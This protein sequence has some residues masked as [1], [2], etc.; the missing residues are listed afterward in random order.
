ML[1]TISLPQLKGT[2]RQTQAGTGFWQKIPVLMPILLL[3]LGLAFFRI[4]Q[5]SFWGDEIA[6]I[7]GAYGDSL[8]AA[9]LWSSGHGPLYFILL[10][11]WMQL[12]QTEF[13]VRSLSA[14][15]AAAAVCLT[16]A[17]GSRLVDRR[18]AAIAATLFAASP[19]VIWY[20]QETRYI[21]LAIVTVLFSMYSFHRALSTNAFKFWLLY[22]CA[23]AMALFAFVPNAFVIMGQGIYVVSLRQR[24]LILRWIGYL[25]AVMLIFGTWLAV[26]YGG[27]TVANITGSAA[28][29]NQVPVASLATG[30]PREL[31]VAVVPYTLFAFTS[32]FSMGP[33][34]E[35]LHVSRELATL[36][37]YLPTLAPLTLLFGMLF[38]LGVSQL[39]RQTATPG[40]LLLWL[41][42]PIVGVLLIAFTTDV[43]YNVRYA[44]AAFPA[45]IFILAAGI[46]KFRHRVVQL[47][48]LLAVLSINGLSLAQYY[49][50]PYYAK[51]DARAAARYMESAGGPQDVILLVGNSGAF[52]YYYEGNLPIV[53][54]GAPI[55]SSGETVRANMHEL[56]KSYDRLWFV[57]IRPWE[58]DPNANVKA[59]L[60]HSL[61]RLHELTLPGVEISSY[62]HGK[63][64]E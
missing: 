8:F 23:T 62:A 10:H 4:D 53:R 31:S 3:Y 6:S 28:E 59:A 37:N 9:S 38:L 16:Y 35:K 20:A 30:T 26:I 34:V 14:I 13:A 33:S 22:A 7:N 36:L 64:G 11:F 39:L 47:G 50:N 55:T 51:A 15:L 58:T 1:R 19:F 57:A 42:I 5:Q 44:C 12:G 21:T 52:S 2:T 46:T 18:Y 29:V 60:D 56:T 24:P 40:V 32:G 54:W 63:S 48:V 61:Q 43:A 49:F 27:A 41:I 25:A 17:L 45:Y